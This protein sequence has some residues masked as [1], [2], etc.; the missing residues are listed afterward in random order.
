MTTTTTA[1]EVHWDREHRA[2]RCALGLIAD[3]ETTMIGTTADGQPVYAI[4]GKTPPLFQVNAGF[5]E[6][7]VGAEWSLAPAVRGACYSRRDGD[8][9]Y[10]SGAPD[11]QQ[12][13]GI[14]RLRD[15]FLADDPT[16]RSFLAVWPD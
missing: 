14:W 3:I 16:R 7:F 4:N 9:L 15:M 6:T 10:L 11:G 8:M 2:Y 12:P 1:I 5:L 13:F